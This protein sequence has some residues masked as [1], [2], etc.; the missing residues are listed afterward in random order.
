MRG[1]EVTVSHFFFCSLFILSSI[2]N[3]R[4]YRVDL[5]VAFPLHDYTT[6]SS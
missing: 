5:V 4:L 6:L 1:I 3:P 2:T